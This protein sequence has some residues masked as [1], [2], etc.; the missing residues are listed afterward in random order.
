MATVA[1]WAGRKGRD[2]RALCARVYA[3]PCETHCLRCGQPVD[4]TLVFSEEL[5]PEVR[6]RARS[7][8]H[9]IPI[10][11][12]GARESRDNVALAHYGCN[13]RHGARM[14]AAK[15]RG[16]GLVASRITLDVDPHSL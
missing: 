8:D 3:D 12:G 7:V 14:V 4:K 13:A 9:I 6:R 5:P 1:R 2:W 16:Q 11:Q 15:R 10:D